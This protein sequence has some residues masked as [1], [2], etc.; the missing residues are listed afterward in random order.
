MIQKE[1]NLNKIAL[2]APA[3]WTVLPM[4]KAVSHQQWL[5]LNSALA[6]IEVTSFPFSDTFP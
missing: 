2:G 4:S 5:G 6:S 3:R 1:F